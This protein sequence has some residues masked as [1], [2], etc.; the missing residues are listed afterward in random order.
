M[1]AISYPSGIC[2]SKKFQEIWVLFLCVDLY[3]SVPFAVMPSS[4]E[5]DLGA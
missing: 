1:Y 2:V 4:F 5:N 3:R